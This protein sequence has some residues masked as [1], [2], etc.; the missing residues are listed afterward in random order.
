MPSIV[1]TLSL[2]NFPFEFRLCRHIVRRI[3]VDFILYHM[4]IW[5]IEA[6][7]ARTRCICAVCRDVSCIFTVKG[8]SWRS[9]RKA[10]RVPKYIMYH[11]SMAVSLQTKT[12]LYC[13]FLLCVVYVRVQRSHA[14]FTHLVEWMEWKKNLFVLKSEQFFTSANNYVLLRIEIAHEQSLSLCVWTAQI[15]FLWD[16]CWY[17]FTHQLSYPYIH[18]YVVCIKFCVVDEDDWKSRLDG[19]LTFRTRTMSYVIVRDAVA[20]IIDF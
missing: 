15:G 16:F 5:R 4:S 19:R 2:I 17:D 1:I 13:T 7:I 10:C 3:S 14:Y 18:M 9:K 8:T 11:I 6:V 12:R 20:V